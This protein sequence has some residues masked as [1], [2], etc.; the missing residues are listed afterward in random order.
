MHTPSTPH[1]VPSTTSP[2]ST[3]LDWPVVHAVVPVS[4]A[5]PFGSHAVP[6]VHALHAPSKHTRFVPHGE[7]LATLPTGSHDDDP[8]AHEMSP[9]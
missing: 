3:Q 7:P 4:H 5:L 2:V 9:V 6:D 8:E 1:G